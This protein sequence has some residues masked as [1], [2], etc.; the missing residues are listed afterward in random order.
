LRDVDARAIYSKVDANNDGNVDMREFIKWLFAENPDMDTTKSAEGEE[1]MD[2][3]KRHMERGVMTK[4]D[5]M[6]DFFQFMTEI[7]EESKFASSKNRKVI[8]L[9]K[10]LKVIEKKDGSRE[11]EKNREVKLRDFFDA[12]DL[13]NNGKLSMSEFTRAL[14]SFGHDG[15]GEML[16]DI[17]RA[18][19]QE[20]TNTRVWDRHYHDLKNQE[21]RFASEG[22][23]KYLVPACEI[24]EKRDMRKWNEDRAAAINDAM[25]AESEMMVE[26]RSQRKEEEE[27]KSKLKDQIKTLQDTIGEKKFSVPDQDRKDNDRLRDLY[28]DLEKCENTIASMTAALN[29]ARFSTTKTKYKDGMIDF[30]EFQKAFE[31]HAAPAA[32]AIEAVA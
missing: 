18:I 9:E 24:F 11:T 30:K 6:T 19:D 12:M 10:D 32:P 26:K 28:R 17:F 3:V 4:E 29:E 1:R 15:S 31:E 25:T 27:N 2:K 7:K 5:A 16:S 20:K 14:T 8:V 22:K 13:N 23:T 21:D